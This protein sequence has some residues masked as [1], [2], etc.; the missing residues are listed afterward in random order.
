L[1]YS[2][3]TRSPLSTFYCLENLGENRFSSQYFAERY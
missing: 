1:K 2:D 3:W